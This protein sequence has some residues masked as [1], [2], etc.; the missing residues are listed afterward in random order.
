MH[1]CFVILLKSTELGK[2]ATIIYTVNKPPLWGR[3]FPDLSMLLATNTIL[4]N[5]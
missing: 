3:R 5:G 1:T 4:R 2:P